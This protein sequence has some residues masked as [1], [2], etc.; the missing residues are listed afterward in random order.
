MYTVNQYSDPRNLVSPRY[1]TFKVRV[2]SSKSIFSVD[3]KTI[4]SDV[5]VQKVDDAISRSLIYP[6]SIKTI[7]R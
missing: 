1:K 4:T 5:D 7:S 2:L 6:I 3:A